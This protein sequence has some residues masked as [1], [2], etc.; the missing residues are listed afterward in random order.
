MSIGIDSLTSMIDNTNTTAAN[1]KA[2]ALQGTLNGDLSSASDD[3]LMD[4]CKEFEAYFMEQVLKEMQETI[5]K[6]EEED[7]SMSQMKEYFEDELVQG[8][9]T[10]ICDQQDLGIAQQMYEQMKRNYGL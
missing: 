10:Q 8:Y 1:S 9:A 6:N 7:A 5:P 3:E 2:N 4:V